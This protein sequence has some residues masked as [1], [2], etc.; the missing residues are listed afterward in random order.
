MSARV[1]GFK[2]CTC[3]PK[4]RGRYPYC[5]TRWMRCKGRIDAQTAALLSSPKPKPRGK[6]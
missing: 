2:G 1:V 4:K 5:T 3:P 6:R